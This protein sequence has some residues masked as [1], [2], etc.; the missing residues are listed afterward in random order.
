M[1]EIEVID[2]LDSDSASA[3]LSARQ[4]K[5]LYEMIQN[6]QSTGGETATTA[7]INAIFA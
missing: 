5:I 1:D 7:E 3:A 6:I 4:G 2:G